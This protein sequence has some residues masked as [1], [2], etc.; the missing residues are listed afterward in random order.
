MRVHQPADRNAEIDMREIDQHQREQETRRR[1]AE[2]AEKGQTVIAEAVLVRRRIDPD[3][4]RDDVGE[5]DRRE[6]HQK[7]QQQPIADHLVDRQVVEEGI[8]HVAVQQPADPVQ[9]LLPQR[10]VEAVLRLE[11]GDL[12]EVGLF[13]LALQLGDIGR[14]IV[15]RRQVDDDEDHDADGDQ[16]RDHDQDPMDEIAEHVTALS[17]PRCRA[18]EQKARRIIRI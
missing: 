10:L 14:E 13:A 11:K 1:Q 12:G 7:R 3:R 4:K 5:D 17:L 18:T 8:A 6:R 9:V 2:E 15:A 16:R